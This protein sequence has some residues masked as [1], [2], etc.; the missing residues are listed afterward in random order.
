ME[1]HCGYLV[2]VVSR[3]QAHGFFSRVLCRQCLCFL[4]Y[5]THYAACCSVGVTEKN[6]NILSAEDM[7]CLSVGGVSEAMFDASE[8]ESGSPLSN[9]LIAASTNGK[10]I[11]LL[12]KH[13]P[14]QVSGAG[15][16]LLPSSRLCSC[17]RGR[18]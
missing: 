17:I 15:G 3:R 1:P 4:S 9:S 7:K 2:G 8:L 11:A 12:L 10:D 5:S 6:V 14:L 13:L 16:H 18:P